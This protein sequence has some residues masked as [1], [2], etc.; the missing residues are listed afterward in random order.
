M[1]QAKYT[2]GQKVTIIS[3]KDPN[4]EKYEGKS[5]VIVENFIVSADDL[6]VKKSLG[7]SGSGSSYYVVNIDGVDVAGLPEESLKP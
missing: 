3:T 7:L 4:F 2:V 6:A 1:E 5:G